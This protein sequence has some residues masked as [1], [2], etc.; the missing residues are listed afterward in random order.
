MADAYKVKSKKSG[1]EYYL[2]SRPAANGTTQL[3]FFA[4]EV[5]EGAVPAMPEGYELSENP[6]TGLPVLKKKK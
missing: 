1:T 5:K 2:H 4:K 3:Y 6:N